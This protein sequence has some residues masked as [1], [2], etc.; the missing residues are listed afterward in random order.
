MYEPARLHMHAT[1]FLRECQWCHIGGGTPTGR[2]PR[3]LQHIHKVNTVSF[4]RIEHGRSL[5]HARLCCPNRQRSICSGAGSCGP[6]M[7]QM[8]EAMARSRKIDDITSTKDDLPPGMH[9]YYSHTRMSRIML[10]HAC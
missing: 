10:M 3:S 9:Y 6:L 1:F 4:C 7:A 5:F 2:V 8:L